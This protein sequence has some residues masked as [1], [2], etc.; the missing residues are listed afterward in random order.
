MD[1]VELHA[2]SALSF[3]RAS[4]PP[5]TLAATAAERGL[6]AMALCDR[7]GVYGIPRFHRAAAEHGIRPLTGC[8]LEMEDDSVLPVLVASSTGYRNLCRLL[9]RSHLA[10]PKGKARI[11]WQALEG[12]TEGL[13]ALTGGPDG[14]LRSALRVAGPDSARDRLRHLREMFGSGHL[15]VELQR[16]RL[17][18]EER[19]VSVLVG[20]AREL[21][22]PVVATNGVLYARPSGRRILDVFTCLRAHQTLDEAGTRL[23]PNSQRHLKTG[24]QMAALFPDLPEAIAN[25]RQIAERLEFTLQDLGYQFPDYSPPG[26][27]DQKAYLSRVTLEGARTRYGAQVPEAVRRQ[28][29]H[30]LDLIHRLGFEGYFLMVWDI[31]NFCRSEGILVQGRGSAANSAV[32]YC[33]GVTAVDAVQ[34]NLLFER[35]LSEG[36]RS[37]PDIDLDLPSGSRR[38]RVIQEIYR[39]H[40]RE[41]AAMTANVITYRG[42]S[43]ARELGRVLCLPPDLV[44]RFMQIQ[45][46]DGPGGAGARQFQHPRFP[47]FL[48]LY[49][50]LQGLP[51]HLGQH[52]GGMILST[53]NLSSVVPLENA[54]MPGRSVAQWDKEDCESLGIIK[55]DL[56][57]LGMM[58]VLQDAV[59][60]CAERGRPVDLATIPK[61]DPAT[62]DLLCAAD[63]VGVFQVESRAQMATLPRMQPRCFYDVCIEVA[64]IRPGPIQGD[65][66][67]PYLARR[68]GQEPETYDD[69]RLEPILKRT[70]G[71]PLFQEQLLRIAMVM[72]DFTASEAEE[73]RRALSFHRSPERMARVTARLEERMAAKGIAPAVIQRMVQAMSSFALYGFPESHAISFAILAYASAWLKVHRTPEFYACLLNNQPMGFYSPATLLQDA[74][75]HGVRI[76][77]P[78]IQN[79]EWHCTVTPQNSLQLGFCQVRNLNTAHV[80]R[81]LEERRTRP[82][83][84]LE[85]LR[86]RVPLDRAEWR[87]LA[88]TGVLRAFS[89][90]RRD[91]LWRVERPPD[92]DLFAFAASRAPDPLPAP[93]S[94]LTPMQAGERLE[95]DYQ[96]LGLSTGPH[97]MK[98]LRPRFPELWRASDLRHG[99]HGACI[100]IAGCLIC[101]QR[102][103]TAK[104]FAFLSLEDESGIANIIV[105]PRLFEEHRLL[106][107]HSSFLRVQG[108]LQIQKGVIHVRAESLE[109]FPQPSRGDEK[110]V[111]APAGNS[112]GSGAI[113]MD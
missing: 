74:R 38:E 60:L 52:S 3:L 25:T 113:G 53:G 77:P 23:S 84:S 28:L 104:G 12:S 63:T 106:I 101:R 50:E 76:H 48:K 93:E 85:D 11:P 111:P 1:Y 64:I 17:R 73:L 62:Y 61:D 72:A 99:T 92:P 49:E 105:T 88:S 31:V 30:E 42:R 54:S 8:E 80:R 19:E 68:S 51:R 110:T 26:G 39:R 7:Q 46:Q 109:L 70:L 87:V 97:P 66:L 13:V 40:G 67:H 71:V 89:S 18:G 10:A 27:T 96:G 36:R 20:L 33:L 37:W 43:A 81:L 21:E 22:V 90:H 86:R 95:A 112:G 75:R 29:A 69:P 15:G 44:E 4:S 98:L 108:R 59:A 34:C 107:L 41:G 83:L 14:P 91:A 102:P 2:S 32:C 82:F 103:S 58:S 57:G 56:L 6:K 5:E 47:V 9:S 16:H 79:S 65:L 94:P 45:A 100:E 78:C 35:F 55:V 24:V